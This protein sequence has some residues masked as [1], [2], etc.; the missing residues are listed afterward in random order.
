MR[1]QWGRAG[2]QV[3]AAIQWHEWEITAQLLEGNKPGGDDGRHS[4]HRRVPD[5][6]PTG[7]HDECHSTDE[8]EYAGQ[9]VN[10]KLLKRDNW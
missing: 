6:N 10:K 9:Q 7:R 2:L 3:S 4:A 1:Q 8:S 5:R